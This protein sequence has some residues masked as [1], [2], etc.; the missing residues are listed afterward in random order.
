M[1]RVALLILTTMLLTSTIG[2]K[3]IAH[4]ENGDSLSPEAGEYLDIQ[5]ERTVKIE[6]GG[7]VLIFDFYTVDNPQEFT[8]FQV[9]FDDS[10]VS[11]RTKFDVWQGDKW[12]PLDYSISTANGYNWYN[13]TFSGTVS[14]KLRASY[15]FLG[16]VTELSDNF[17]ASIPVYPVL[18]YNASEY[19]VSVELPLDS[20]YV[21][22]TAPVNF[23]HFIE[24]GIDY[25]MHVA[26]NFTSF[27]N[28]DADVKYVPSPGDRYI[29]NC[30]RL[31]RSVTVRQGDL[32]LEDNYEIENL[33]A[34]FST[35]VLS[36]PGYASSIAARDAIDDLEIVTRE[37]ASGLIEVTVTPKFQVRKGDKWKFTL[38]Y[39]RPREGNIEKTGG[40]STLTFWTPDFPH[41]VRELTA[42]VY[43]PGGGQYISSEPDATAVTEEG[44][45]N[46]AI[47]RFGERLPLETPEIV[48]TLKESQSLG[49][50][51]PLGVAV[52]V[53]VLVGII[54][55]MRRRRKGTIVPIIRTDKPA[56]S[57]FIEEYLERISLL[58]ELDELAQRSD[59]GEIEREEFEM[60]SAEIN[61]R[62]REMAGSLK[63]KR[64][65]LGEEY[66]ELFDGFREIRRAEEDLARVEED[67]RNLEVRL[68]ARRVT[69]REH[70]RRKEDRLSRRR[71][72]IGRMEKA[73]A[74]LASD[75]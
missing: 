47:F 30:H 72:I 10:Q 15:L 28:V 35:F 66:P 26:H 25:V 36:V 4:A 8:E 50:A 12:I 9:G 17:V 43:V 63:Q 21:G 14:L 46:V 68:R 53:C 3:L 60:R 64:G 73:L 55:I 59:D 75:S 74:L 1:R 20:V 2:I 49:Y 41:Y 29:L 62:Q 67:L 6:E 61:R 56:L 40:E 23:T 5:A 69:R 38:A 37:D 16:L 27:S 22:T 71:Q 58:K 34:S 70:E 18:T 11:E 51:V 52:A 45:F 57:G 13:L 39:S 65:E 42:K 44:T 33:G 7:K 19:S 48:V 24:E 32:R 54:Y 31:E